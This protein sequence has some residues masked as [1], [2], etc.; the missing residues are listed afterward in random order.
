MAVKS[1]AYSLLLGGVFLISEALRSAPKTIDE[2]V[3]IAKGQCGPVRT[4]TTSLRCE[5]CS[6]I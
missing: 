6:S 2:Q 3:T 5:L 1:K 4:S